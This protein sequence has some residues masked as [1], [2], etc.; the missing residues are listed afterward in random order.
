MSR[1]TR[2]PLL[3]FLALG[4]GLFALFTW[5]DAGTSQQR[6]EQIVVD[7][8]RLAALD[9][10]FR[11]VWR[12]EPTAAERQGLVDGWV[13]EEILYRE[14]LALG[15]DQDDDVIRRRVAQKVAF[16]SEDLM[17]VEPTAEALAAW[18]EPR[19]EDYR[20]EPIHTFQQVFFDPGR[21]GGD[22][23]GELER[24][25]QA[26]TVQAT[27]APLGDATL[28]PRALGPAG[29]TEI[30][31]TFGAAFAAA[32]AELPLHRWYGPVTSEYG[33]H[34]VLIEQRFPSRLPEL[35]E[36]RAAVA[37]DYLYEQSRL[38][39]ERFYQG[40]RARYD[41]LVESD[42]PEDGG[43]NARSAD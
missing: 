4:S 34:L 23:A 17:T 27:A 7:D 10:Q 15:L 24:A 43:R 8:A 35:D 21:H 31:R 2:E 19:R 32:L 9:T 6:P 5:L 30:A 41:V 16:I 20:V 18:F 29:T 36:V 37:R 1:W 33:V 40:L 25:R 14:G 42:R 11:R 12:R 22:L 3:H 26:L 28:L 13:R 38:A 39:N